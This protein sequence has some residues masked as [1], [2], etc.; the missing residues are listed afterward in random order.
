[1]I[2][3]RD[4]SIAALAAFVVVTT[5]CGDSRSEPAAANGEGGVV[6]MLAERRDTAAAEVV[7]RAV[8]A[9]LS[10]V[11]VALEVVWIDGLAPDLPSQIAKAEKVAE[12]SAAVAVIW[13]DLARADRIYLYFA[14]PSGGRVLV[15]EL[16]GSGTGGM[17]EALAIIVRSSVEAVLAGGEIGTVVPRKPKDEGSDRRPPSAVAKAKDEGRLAVTAAYEFDVVSS[18]NPAV[19][20]VAVAL[21]LRLGDHL[22]LGVGYALSGLLEAETDGAFLKLRRHPVW[23][24]GSAFGRVG[25]VRLGLD[26]AFQLDV[27]TERTRATAAGVVPAKGGHEVEPSIV[28]MFRVAVTVIPHLELFIAAGADIALHRTRYMVDTARG[29][30]EVLTTWPVRPRGIAGLEAALW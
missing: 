20:A 19:H 5:F 18:S 3:K 11:S 15:R 1:V 21:S 13:C 10:D 4:V 16:A 6:V 14:A 27:V 7:I 29:P 30:V 8:Q 26:L 2:G 12:G 9:Q 28:P 23:I 22:S 17:A 24:G 25:R